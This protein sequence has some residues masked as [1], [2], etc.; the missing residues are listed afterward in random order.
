MATTYTV[1]QKKRLVGRIN[2]IKKHDDLKKIKDIIISSEPSIDYTKNS[3]G[4]L[5]QFSS[6]RN[7]TYVNIEKFLNKIENKN[8]DSDT[9]TN[10]TN[11]TNSTN[12][13]S[14]Y[15]TEKTKS[16]DNSSETEMS[17]S[18]NKP[19]SKKLRLT[20]TE[21]HILNRAK[22]EKE[23]KKNEREALNMSDDNIYDY[24]KIMELSDSVEKP[25]DIFCKKSR[26]K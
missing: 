20:N 18:N 13:E 2:N 15:R 10:N 7:N 24:N 3:N 4:F 19:I 22:Y 8:I 5:F 1:E 6:L 23:L 16:S 14:S 9:P 12:L 25:V 11:N 21:N 26:R 17:K